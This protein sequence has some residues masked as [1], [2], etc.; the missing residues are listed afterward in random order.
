MR[1]SS[2]IYYILL[3]IYTCIIIYIYIY[4]WW[5]WWLRRWLAQAPVPAPLTRHSADLIQLGR[6]TVAHG[7]AGMN[8]KELDHEAVAYL[9]LLVSNIPLNVHSKP[10]FVG[11]NW[12]KP[13]P[14][15]P[16]TPQTIWFSRE[17]ERIFGTIEWG[18]SI[19][20]DRINDVSKPMFFLDLITHPLRRIHMNLKHKWYPLN[21]IFLT[22]WR[23]WMLRYHS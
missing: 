9:K 1:S 3:Y 6:C 12:Y 10:T 22:N 5:R 23:L 21:C 16:K 20:G 17:L 18:C 11:H 8:P 2:L 19:L 4:I 15:I 7:I 14:L 13:I